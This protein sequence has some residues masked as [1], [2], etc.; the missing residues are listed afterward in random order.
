MWGLI[1]TNAPLFKQKVDLLA[2][3]QIA[4]NDIENDGDDENTTDRYAD[5]LHFC[6]G[7]D[8]LV[9]LIDPKYYSNSQ[10]EMLHVLDSMPALL[11]GAVWNKRRMQWRPSFFREKRRWRNFLQCCIQS[12]PF[13]VIFEWILVL[14]SCDREW[15][16]NQSKSNGS[17][18]AKV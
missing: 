6:I 8:A 7:M 3:L 11:W 4:V 17:N 10:D 12:L 9:R 1:L 14:Q 15:H 2:P 18:Q 5:A 13:F 16:K